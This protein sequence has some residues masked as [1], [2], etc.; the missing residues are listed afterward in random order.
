MYMPATVGVSQGAQYGEV[1]M[2]KLATA[3]AN[4]YKQGAYGGVFN[5]D[6]AKKV[7][8]EAGIAFSDGAE[9]AVKAAADTLSLGRKLLLNLH[10]V[11]L[12]IIDLKWYSK[13]LV[14]GHLVIH[15]R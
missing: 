8:D 14:D 4:V 10:L 13:E 7:Y 9:T 12:Q 1:E 5:K 3:V 2:G 15:L 6:F 11:E